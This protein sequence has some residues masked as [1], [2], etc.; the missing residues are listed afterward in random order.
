MVDRESRKKQITAKRRQQILDAALD[1]FSKQGYAAS[2]MPEIARAAG[3]AAG[4]IYI[5][6]PSKRELFVS[7]IERLMVAPMLNIFKNETG[8][9]FQK[10]LK[11]ALN[12][13]LSILQSVLLTKL[14]SLIGEIQRDAE[15]RAIFMEKLIGP[16]LARMEEL[17]RARIEAGEFRP[18]EPAI[19]VRLVGGMMLGMNLL[20]SIEGDISPLSRLP[21]GQIIDEMINFVFFGLN[22]PGDNQRVA[23]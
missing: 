22:Q 8:D 21:P 11:I 4:T 12:E 10:T 18:M 6:F 19:T 23:K 15:L 3:L 7:V 16:F 20:K 13:R 17:Y 2:T 14:L 1:L 5:Y 9:N